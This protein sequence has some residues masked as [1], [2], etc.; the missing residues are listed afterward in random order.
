M[1]RTDAEPKARGALEYGTDLEAPRMLWAALVRSP[2]G[3][4]A[5]RANGLG[6]RPE[7]AGVVAVVGPDDLRTLLPKAA[8]EAERPVFPLDEYPVPRGADRRGG[9]RDP[10]AGP[11]RGGRSSP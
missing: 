9:G 4:W 3:A 7:D 5:H 11:P 6:P 1:T 2:V 8:L 10:G